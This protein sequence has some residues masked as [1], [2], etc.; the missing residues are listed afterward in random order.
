LLWVGVG[1]AIHKY[2]QRQGKDIEE[3]V[4][5]NPV[6]K[7]WSLFFTWTSFWLG[8]RLGIRHGNYEMQ[9]ENLIAFTPLFPV[10]SRSNYA[11]SVTFYIYYQLKNPSL[12]SL[13]GKVASVNLTRPGH[14]FAFDE[15]IERF[16]KGQYWKDYME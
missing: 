3:L 8:H 14:F 10:A 4:K 5:T 15:G 11:Q 6:L 7:V 12:R 2:S 9:L 1:I 13:L 16:G